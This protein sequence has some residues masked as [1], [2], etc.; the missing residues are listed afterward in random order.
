MFPW[1][2]IWTPRFDFP[3][4]GNVTQDVA[5]DWFFSGIRSKA[6]NAAL[7]KAIFNHATYGKQLGVVTDAL[8]GL[9]A[10]ESLEPDQREETKT[11]LMALYADIQTIKEQH[12]QDMNQQVNDTIAYLQ[13]LK[14]NNPEAFGRI[15]R[16]FQPDLGGEHA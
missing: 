6:G 1:F 4:S 12:K 14:V 16:E 5:T 9:L 8:V 11:Q 15:L 3:L 2:W 10:P 7:E 13:S